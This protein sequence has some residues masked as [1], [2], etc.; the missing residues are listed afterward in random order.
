LNV[1]WGNT[2]LRDVPREG[3]PSKGLVPRSCPQK[4][5]T[6]MSAHTVITHAQ[7]QG[8]TPVRIIT[9]SP[10]EYGVS[11]GQTPCGWGGH[12]QRCATV[13][14]PTVAVHVLRIDLPVAPTGTH[15][16][17][18]HSPWDVRTAPVGPVSL[19]KPGDRP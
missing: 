6:I 12:Y 8:A 13:G 1:T 4:E 3:T 14:T 16:C 10:D 9:A 7:N 5:A 19:A 18:Y 15:L 11:D 17:A 2:Y